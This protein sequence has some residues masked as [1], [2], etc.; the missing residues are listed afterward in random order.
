MSAATSSI[1]SAGWAHRWC[2]HARC[3]SHVSL[4]TSLCSQFP[5][6]SCQEFPLLSKEY[7]EQ[8][9][10]DGRIRVEGTK[11][12]RPL[13][14][15]RKGQSLCWLRRPS[16][17]PFNMQCTWAHRC[18]RTRRSRGAGA[19]ATLCTAMSRRCWTPP[20]R[21]VLLEPC[22]ACIHSVRR[23]EQQGRTSLTA[24]HGLSCVSAAGAGHDRRCAGGL[25]AGVHA[26]ACR[27]AAP[28]EHRLRPAAGASSSCAQQEICR[29]ACKLAAI[30]S[31]GSA[32]T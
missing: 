31:A 29:S 18:R 9:F 25:Q 8:A 19:C 26:G 23:T 3:V 6:P 10:E 24:A 11:V 32:C 1:S 14:S 7:V 16:L 28:K 15:A 27:W 20:L 5:S 2:P 4:R 30:V 21:R 22:A 13:C 17:T 12:I